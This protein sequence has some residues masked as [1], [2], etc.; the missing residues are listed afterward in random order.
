MPHS[1]RAEHLLVRAGKHHDSQLLVDIQ[2]AQ[3]GWDNIHF[4]VR[5]LA[6]GTSWQAATDDH[7]LAIVP[8]SGVVQVYS[9]RGDW[10]AVGGRVSV[11]AGLPHALYLP[12][13]TVFEVRAIGASQFA[14]AWVAADR[15]YAPQLVT[16]DQVAIEI[17]GGDHATRQ[18]NSILPPGFACQRLV[19]VEVLTPA[20]NWSSYPPH[21]HDRHRTDAAGTLLEA[22]LEE[23]YYYQFDR[24]EGFAFQHIYTDETSPL[25]QA[26][27]SID[28][29]LRPGQHDVVLVPEGYHPVSA[30]PGYNTYYLNV[31]AGSAQ[32][33]ANYED[34]RYAW[35][36]ETYQARDPRVP[37]YSRTS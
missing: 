31:L 14:V 3:A 2:P 33:L 4:Q 7:E 26:G 24:P 17:R 1:Y 20:G 29:V 30:P 9:N 10:P 34:P 5:E 13:Q 37:F 32:S 23:I 28:A 22:D 18:I 11:F 27:H 16:P 21:K 8:L 25:H 35:V 6:A 36:K 15:D 12:R 19:I